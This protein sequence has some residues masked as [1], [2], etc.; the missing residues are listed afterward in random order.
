MFNVLAQIFEQA[1]PGTATDALRVH[2]GQLSRWLDE[3]WSAGPP[4]IP[5]EPASFVV[6]FL[7]SPPGIIATLDSPTTP[8]IFKQPSGINPPNFQSYSGSAGPTTTTAGVPPIWH[9]LMYAYLLENTGLV[10]IFSEVLRRAVYGETLEIDTNEAVQW[11]RST[12]DLFFR[13][14]PLFSSGLMTSQLRPETRIIRRNAY[15]RMF[16][17]DLSHPIPGP[18]SNGARDWK[19]FTANGVNTTF[20]EKWAELLRQIWLGIENRNNLVGA[21]ATDDAYLLLL[22]QTLRD[23]LNMRRR[24]GSLAREEFDAVAMM[25]WFDLTLSANTPI[26]TGLNAIATTKWDRLSLVAQKVGMK[27]AP[28]AEEMFEL[29]ELMS[30]FLRMIEASAFNTQANVQLFYNPTTLIYST[31]NRIIDLWQSATGERVK[32]RPAGNVVATVAAQPLRVPGA[33][34]VT[35]PRLVA[36]SAAGGQP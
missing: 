19:Q 5:V 18:A 7:G 27:P 33:Q 28:R 17:L 1:S 13:D 8:N 24:A 4:Q 32:D 26:I 30:L 23:M 34:P 31:M 22:C 15:W 25:S 14:P 29:A 21:K 9:H 36:R 10:E 12:E 20:R 2:P 11:L 3:V 6:P 35:A 16:G